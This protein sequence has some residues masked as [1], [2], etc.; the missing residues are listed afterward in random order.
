MIDKSNQFNKELQELASF[1]KVLSHPARIQILQ[2]LINKKSCTC[3]DIVSEL[4]LAQSTVSQHLKS[5][6]EIGIIDGE[7]D[8]PRVCYCINIEKMKRLRDS[9]MSLFQTSFN[10]CC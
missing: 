4:P 1:A 2:E 9:F 7:V 3:L 10:K 8:G 6:K 5:L